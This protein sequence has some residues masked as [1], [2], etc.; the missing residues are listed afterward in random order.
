MYLGGRQNG[1]Q[2]RIVDDYDEE[3]SDNEGE[4]GYANE[5]KDDSKYEGEGRR[6]NDGK[7]ATL[8]GPRNLEEV[9]TEIGHE[10]EDDIDE[11]EWW[12]GLSWWR[13]LYY[14]L[15]GIVKVCGVL[16][17]DNVYDEA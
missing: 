15:A 9:K 6:G 13:K 12:A 16:Y 8:K 5:V 14:A 7:S 17:L 2:D 1:Y 4:N 10:A 3:E 11:R